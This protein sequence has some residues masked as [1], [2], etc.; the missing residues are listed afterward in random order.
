MTLEQQAALARVRFTIIS[1]IKAS[2]VFIMLIGLWIWYGDVLDKGGNALVGGLLFALGFF[3]SLVLPRILIR[4][5]RTPP[6]P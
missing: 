6:Q 1:A 2:G 5:W 4:R 3:E